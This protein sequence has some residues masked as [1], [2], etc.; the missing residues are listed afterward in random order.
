MGEMETK[1]KKP[2]GKDGKFN[3]L[4]L[5]NWKTPGTFG[6]GDGLYIQVRPAKGG[7]VVKCWIF[8]YRDRV[9]RKLRDMG[10]GKFPRVS[11]SEAREAAHKQAAMLQ[12]F[13]DPMLEREQ[14]REEIIEKRRKMQ[15]FEAAATE[16]WN[17]QKAA[18]K[19]EKEAEVWISRMK[20]HAFP[21]LGS[22]LVAGIKMTHVLEVLDPIWQEKTETARKVRQYM[23]N[24]FDFAKGRGLYLGDNPAAWKGNLEA[25]LPEAGKIH[26]AKNH[27]AL[28]YRQ[29][30]AFLEAVRGQKTISYR[31]LEFAALTACRSSE[32]LNAKWDEIDFDE[33][34][35]TIGEERMKADKAH[36]VPL[37]ARALEILRELEKT[38]RDSFV[39]PGG[40]AGKPLSGMSMTEAIKEMDRKRRLDDG[41]GWTDAAG[42]RITTH[43]LRSTFRDWCGNRT[44]FD[45]Q[46]VEFALAHKLPDRV[47]AAYLRT[48]LIEKR[49]LLMDAWGEFCA[50]TP[51][52]AANVIPIRAAQ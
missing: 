20:T 40:K 35:W 18:W 31:A 1:R 17:R 45:R 12:D 28:D 15:T 11:L 33:A 7:G 46:T 8:R 2:A 30:G 36:A 16:Y 5:K 6:E 26:K 13:K 44:T 22:K 14:Q 25:Q 23:E 21:A 52:D 10:L 42:E 19:S 43:G 51:A 38:K 9:T 37:N 29:I 34:L 27:P 32:V 50:T 3:D 48:T 47:E 49:R 39:F 4:A 24:V 41:K